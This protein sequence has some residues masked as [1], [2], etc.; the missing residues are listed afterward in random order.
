MA[1][2]WAGII[3]MPVEELKKQLVPLWK[4]V[5]RGR[6]KRLAVQEYIIFHADDLAGT[7]MTQERIQN[8]FELFNSKVVWSFDPDET[9]IQEHQ[10][11][12]R[13]LLRFK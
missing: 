3:K 7:G 4:G 11:K 8:T 5:P 6:V 10:S 2:T 12:L 9:Q 13:E 1:E